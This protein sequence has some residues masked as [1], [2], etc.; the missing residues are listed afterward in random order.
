[1]KKD[2]YRKSITL[3]AQFGMQSVFTEENF[4]LLSVE[5]MSPFTGTFYVKVKNE[6]TGQ[7]IRFGK[8]NVFDWFKLEKAV[9]AY[10]ERTGKNEPTIREDVLYHIRHENLKLQRMTML[11]A[12]FNKFFKEAREASVEEAKHF[13]LDNDIFHSEVVFI[14]NS[15]APVFARKNYKALIYKIAKSRKKK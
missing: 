13:E 7:E 9:K 12:L 5:P 6:N 4:P 1:M 14:K 8:I 15:L 11:A 2:I 3:I 10:N